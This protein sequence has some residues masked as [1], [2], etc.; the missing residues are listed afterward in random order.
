MLPKSALD[1]ASQRERWRSRAGEKSKWFSRPKG[2]TSSIIT[3][4]TPFANLWAWS[5]VPR[6]LQT[7]RASLTEKRTAKQ[8]VFLNQV[9]LVEQVVDVEDQL[10]TLSELATHAGMEN[11]VRG[12]AAKIDASGNAFFVLDFAEGQARFERR[13]PLA[14]FLVATLISPKGKPDSNWPISSAEVRRPV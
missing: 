8:I 1:L 12:R 10:Q 11:Q 9:T 2:K 5:K 13:I 3:A 4:G 14:R 7:Q 6:R